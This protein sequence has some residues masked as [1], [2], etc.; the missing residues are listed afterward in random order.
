MEE[1]ETKIILAMSQIRERKLK[2]KISILM[3][4][5]ENDEHEKSLNK[6]QFKLDIIRLK[7][8]HENDYN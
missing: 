2:N 6:L 1:K 3:L 5:K 4:N 8:E 7:T